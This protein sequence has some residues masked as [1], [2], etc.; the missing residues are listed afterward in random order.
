MIE[1]WLQWWGHIRIYNVCVDFSFC[2]SIR[3]RLVLWTEL[4]LFFKTSFHP[5]SYWTPSGLRKNW[6]SVPYMG[7]MMF[8]VHAKMVVFSEHAQYV[9]CACLLGGRVWAFPLM[10][11]LCAC[12]LCLLIIGSG[13]LHRTLSYIWWRLYLPTFLLSIGLSH[14]PCSG[15]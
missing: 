13:V 10:G 12:P 9:L 4:W 3:C 15:T 11:V 2:C 8:Y 14:G 6:I 1:A 7:S 5:D